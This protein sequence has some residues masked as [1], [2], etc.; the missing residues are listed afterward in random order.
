MLKELMSCFHDKIEMKP[1]LWRC[2]VSIH[3]HSHTLDNSWLWG[4]C[5]LE[6]WNIGLQ[7]SSKPFKQVCVQALHFGIF[8][9]LETEM[10]CILRIGSL[11]YYLGNFLSSDM[12][13]SY[14]NMTWTKN[15]NLTL[16][17]N[18]YWTLTFAIQEKVSEVD[19]I[20]LE[21]L[22]SLDFC[23]YFQMLKK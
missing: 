9:L 4:K 20:S 3:F 19:A 23:L 18:A 21:K 1:I 17:S 12:Q 2:S 5:S 7:L 13:W 11:V 14:W 22:I 8:V 15:P 16:E 6:L 10:F